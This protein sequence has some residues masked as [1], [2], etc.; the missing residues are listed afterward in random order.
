MGRRNWC[1]GL[2]FAAYNLQIITVGHN[3]KMFSIA[4]MPLVLAGMH[5][6]YKGKYLSGA[7]AALLGLALLISNSMVQVDYYL[8]VF[9]MPIFVIG[10]LIE[11]I[12]ANAI[13]Q[14]IIGSAIMLLVGL[15]S[16]APSLDQVMVSKEYAKA[17]M[18]G[19]Q[20]EL[21][22][23]KKKSKNGGLDKEYAFRWSQG[24]GETFTLLSPNLYGVA[25]EWM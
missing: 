8:I 19:G 13:K 25:E 5:W 16:V 22:L 21:T 7:S 6:V 1:S 11:A 18:R 10:Y 2:Y 3:T 20:S 9:I 14:F 15:L 12:K 24:L 23:G 17:T 4:Y